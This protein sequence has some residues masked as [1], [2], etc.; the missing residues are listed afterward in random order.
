MVKGTNWSVIGILV[1]LYASP[2]VFFLGQCSQWLFFVFLKRSELLCFPPFFQ[3]KNGSA[4]QSPGWSW[5]VCCCV[6]SQT[7][8]PFPAF[9]FPLLSALCVS[10]RPLW[11]YVHFFSFQRQAGLR[12]LLTT[13]GFHSPGLLFFPAAVLQVVSV[14]SHCHNQICAC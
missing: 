1:L 11:V 4:I 6:S 5:I 14:L 13:D 12:L 9:I 8:R 7:Q 2:W 10:S 3:Q